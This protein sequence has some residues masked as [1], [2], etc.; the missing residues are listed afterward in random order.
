MAI[1]FL[2]INAAL[3]LLY[4]FYRL[5]VSRDTFF[6]LRRMTLWLIY[7]VAL[8][9]PVLNLEYWVRDTPSM[10]GMANVYADAIYP[11][12][13]VRAQAPGI[14]WMDVVMGIYWI[15]VAW[16][17]LR[18]VWQLAS[19]CRLAFIAKK[20]K[21][22]GVVVHV[23]EGEGSPFSFFHWI[24][25]YPQT[26][27]GGQ[28][29]EVLVH[30]CTHA[31]GLHSVDSIFSELFTVLCWF[32]PFA[33][34]MK[35]EV[36]IN[37]EYLA[38]ESVLSD[39]NARKSYQYHLLG[40]AYRKP[41]QSSTEI[42]NNFNLLPLKKRIEMMNKRRT[43]EIGKA[44]YLLFAPLAGALLMVS[45][46]ESVAREIGKQV[47]EI[48]QIQE[49]A[50]QMLSLD[51]VDANPR[52]D[53]MV[54]SKKPTETL[55]ENMVVTDS[56][57]QGDKVY[58]V[59]E[60][61][62]EFPGGTKAMMYFLMKTV[63]YPESAHE[64]HIEGRVIASFVI[65]KDG[66][67]SNAKIERSVDPAL[68]AEALRV[69]SLMP[70]WTPGMQNG[71]PVAVRYTVPLV[72]RLSEEDRVDDKGAVKDSQTK[73]KKVMD[74]EGFAE[75]MPQFPGGNIEMIKFFGD[76][77]KYPEAAKKAN[78]QGSVI[79][80]FTVTKDGNI[81]NAKVVRSVHP[82]LDAEALRVVNM[83][84]KWTPGTQFG[85]TVDVKYTVPVK[86]V[87]PAVKK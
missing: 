50:E 66:S 35:Q 37:L 4:G 38:D 33:W 69:V 55:E 81:E 39:G 25:V 58:D 32:N 57:K 77:I 27:N 75:I 10:M 11:I 7:I 46:I 59:V 51:V 85:K 3:M 23:L 61:M 29:H 6:S 54:E 80:T 72:F 19:I 31:H 13:V 68:D 36:R 62:P 84:P 20:Q 60:K 12:V 2:K 65:G 30:E 21:V 40:L 63:R 18:V 78:A 41:V 87:K 28:L 64:A 52:L 71:K 73:Q 17:S 53:E 45:N 49:K 15:G 70:K 14:T 86:F 5:T 83:M 67:I 1:Y 9:V 16:F 48:A 74:G 79:V 47:P 42:A 44:K 34:L 26:L 24:F 82:A 76:N 8:L 43:S 22:E 56:M